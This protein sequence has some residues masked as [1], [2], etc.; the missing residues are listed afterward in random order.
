MNKNK[1]RYI[2]RFSEVYKCWVVCCGKVL[3]ATFS[4]GTDAHQQERAE[5]VADLLNKHEEEKE[6]TDFILETEKYLFDL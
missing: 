5:L 3:Y 6:E 2:A 1:T 4:W